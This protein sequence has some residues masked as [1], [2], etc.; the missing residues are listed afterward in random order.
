[1]GGRGCG[2]ESEVHQAKETASAV[3]EPKQPRVRNRKKT[4]WL[5]GTDGGRMVG[6]SVDE[7]EVTETLASGAKLKQMPQNSVI[8]MNN[9]N[10]IFKN[11]N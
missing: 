6:D 7:H 4:A 5:A 10:E 11:H 2:S 9:F 1:M 8:K 3:T